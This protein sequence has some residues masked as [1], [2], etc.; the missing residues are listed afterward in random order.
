M[1][2]NDNFEFNL[3]K[4]CMNLLLEQQSSTTSSSTSSSASSSQEETKTLNLQIKRE[5][6]DKLM[7][8]TDILKNTVRHF[9]PSAID[10]YLSDEIISFERKRDPKLEKISI[11]HQSSRILS[12][13]PRKDSVFLKAFA[14]CCFVSSCEVKYQLSVKSK[15]FIH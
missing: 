14:R 8:E 5:T 6:F 10:K 3:E 4:E 9:K 2:Q 13:L 12:S 11:Q 15:I 1:S 7:A